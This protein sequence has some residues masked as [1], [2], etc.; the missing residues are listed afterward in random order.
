[1]TSL[2]PQGGQFPNHCGAFIHQD[3]LMRI[4][5]YFV[6]N[7]VQLLVE[8]IKTCTMA[9]DSRYFTKFM[10]SEMFNAVKIHIKFVWFF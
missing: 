10:R 1:L 8:G 6:I 3:I 4:F 5:E 2:T 9:F 7:I